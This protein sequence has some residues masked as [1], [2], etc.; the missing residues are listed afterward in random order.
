LLKNYAFSKRKAFK[1]CEPVAAVVLFY[2]HLLKWEPP[3]IC[4]ATLDE[5]KQYPHTDE[6]KC[7]KE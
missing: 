5:E 6:Q 3:G 2:R 7:Q 4:R 1:P